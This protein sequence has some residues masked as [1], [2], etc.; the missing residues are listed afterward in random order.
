MGVL[1]RRRTVA[2]VGAIAMFATLAPAPAHAWGFAAH[3][4]IM[5]RAIDLL[6]AE[7]KPFYERH[8]DELV[9]RVVD[10]DLWRNVGWEDDP[11]HF[12]DFGV[13]EYGPYPFK[14]LPRDYDA[15]LEKFGAATL[16]QY[17]LLP[18]R[19]AEMFGQLRRAFEGFA[20]SNPYAVSDAVLF[21][22]VTAHYVQD[23]HQ[24]LHATDNYDGGQTNQR[25]IHARFERDLFER[26]Q[27]R[28]TIAPA[29]PRPP[30]SPRD[31]AFAILLESYQR[32]PELLAADREA[33]GTGEVY[34]DAYFERFFVKV[35]PLLEKRIGDAITATA[36]LIVG[37]WEQAGRPA[38]R[39]EMPRA[40][41]QRRP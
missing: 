13:K 17:G 18:W 11:N 24:P 31:A 36:S 19:T 32:V 40:P 35:R 5:G 10:P 28:L 39:T 2:A 29:P 30:A 3:R 15:A 34:D 14:E 4:F 9:L 21:S 27:S 6:P 22:A 12:L 23:A 7:L 26:F 20:R 41:Q 25:G 33:I 8:R 1:F 37:A 16:R 38:L